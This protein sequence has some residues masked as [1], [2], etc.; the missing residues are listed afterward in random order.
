MDAKKYLSRKTA[1]GAM[2]SKGV[3]I[4]AVGI[5]NIS[6]DEILPSDSRYIP[7]KCLSRWK[8]NLISVGVAEREAEDPRKETLWGR[9]LASALR[10]TY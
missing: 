7:P 6:V 10:N 2:N 1:E 4:Y 5:K 3:M 9:Q 8:K